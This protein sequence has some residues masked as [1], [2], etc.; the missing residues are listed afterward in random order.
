[1]K[2]IK[3]FLLSLASSIGAMAADFEVSPGQLEGLLGSDCK[4]Q[5]ELKFT[6]KIDARDLAALENLSTDVKILD[7]SGVK[8][9]ALSMPTRKYFGRTLFNE[10][11]IPAYTFFKTNVTSIILPQEV[12]SICEGA[13]AGSSITE[14]VIPEGV[15][16]IGD[17]A[18]YGCTDLKSVT[19][20]STLKSIGK[21]AFSN[22]LSLREID[23]S[24]TGISEVPSKAFAGSVELK[25]VKLPS[26]VT[27]VGREAFSHTAVEELILNNVKQ[28]EEFALSSMPYLEKLAINPEAGMSEGLLMDDTSLYSL[29]GVPEYVPDYFAANCGKLSSELL[30]NAESLGRYSFANT[31]APEVLVLP[32]Y[33]S[34]I[35]RGALS[36]LGSIKKIDATALDSSVPVVDEYTFEG[37]NPE[38]IELWVADS[39][40]DAWENHP[41]WNKFRVMS[42]EQ[43]GIDDIASEATDGIEIACRNGYVVIESPSTINDV[44]IYTADG[45]MAYVASPAEN[46]VEI[47]AATLPAGIVIVA[48][49]DDEG[50]KANISL[51]LR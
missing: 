41:V 33:L 27:K 22:C 26:T 39:A 23:L 21:G 18:F 32:S 37:I 24:K 36:G 20:P 16:S 1:M 50:R 3:I 17:Y 38:T 34:S 46:R 42:T 19:L 6:G 43:T 28:F 49:S 51:L 4:G 15:T 47:D 31:M 11:E 12:K 7:L 40:F 29:T 35:D 45:R 30:T 2:P 25:T 9:E 48:A 10:G 14:I 13:L 5:T 44:R 8:I